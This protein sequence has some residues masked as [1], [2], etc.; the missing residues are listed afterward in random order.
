MGHPASCVGDA[1]LPTTSPIPSLYVIPTSVR[2]SPIPTPVPSFMARGIARASHWRMPN[3]AKP[4]KMKPSTK[5]ACQCH[6]IGHRAGAVVSD[7]TVSKVGVE[8]HPRC[9]GD[10]SAGC[11]MLAR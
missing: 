6:S 11:R 2:S 10:G 8:A 4:K 1:V 5:M 3:S 9:Q 7:D